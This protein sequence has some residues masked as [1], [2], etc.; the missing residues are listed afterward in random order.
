MYKNRERESRGVGIAIMLCKLAIGNR[1]EREGGRWRS[2]EREGCRDITLFTFSSR[3]RRRKCF[4]KCRDNPSEA[5][6][7]RRV[8]V[9]HA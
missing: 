6:D 8:G 5:L 7:C 4:Y 3:L 9:L 1:T 2:V